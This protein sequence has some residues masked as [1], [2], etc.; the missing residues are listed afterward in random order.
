MNVNCTAGHPA[1][2]RQGHAIYYMLYI[3][4]SGTNHVWSFDVIAHS[5]SGAFGALRCELAYKSADS[6]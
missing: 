6:W 2:V 1:L 4:M 3:L 5:L